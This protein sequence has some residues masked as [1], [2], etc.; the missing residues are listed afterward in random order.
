MCDVMKRLFYSIGVY[1]I[2][3]EL[4]EEEITELDTFHHDRGGGEDVA[5]MVFIGGNCVGGLESLVALHLSGHLV[6]QLV[7]IGALES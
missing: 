5:P 6:A 3:V 1:P 4:E 7:E 2:V